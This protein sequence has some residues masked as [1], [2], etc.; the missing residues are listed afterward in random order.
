MPRDRAA[1]AI[2]RSSAAPGRR[3]SRRGPRSRAALRAFGLPPLH[4]ASASRIARTLSRD[5]GAED[6]R[7]VAERLDFGARERGGN[8]EEIAALELAAAALD[9]AIVHAKNGE[10]SAV[11]RARGG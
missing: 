2:P 3:C 4:V 5:R 8:E 7:S 10:A 11:A 1:S 9:G 6:A